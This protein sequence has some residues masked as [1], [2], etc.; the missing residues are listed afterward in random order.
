MD[1]MITGAKYSAAV[2]W[3]KTDLR[4]LRA[5]YPQDGAVNRWM[6]H[7]SPL[8]TPT[9]KKRKPKVCVG[10]TKTSVKVTDSSTDFYL[11]KS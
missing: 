11:E 5:S 1:H 8:S 3:R 4:H 10:A 9:K 6:T 7:L 2:A